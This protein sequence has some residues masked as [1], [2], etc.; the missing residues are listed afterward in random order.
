VEVKVEA[1]RGAPK[2]D[3]AAAV[4]AKLGK[5]VTAK[6]RASWGARKAWK[7]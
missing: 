2:E 4:A 1:E 7:R 6:E 3:R 5:K